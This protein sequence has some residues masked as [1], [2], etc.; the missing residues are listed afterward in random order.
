MAYKGATPN[1]PLTTYLV[2]HLLSREAETQY[3]AG[4]I[5]KEF[6]EPSIKALRKISERY[7]QHS[8]GT[9]L[10]HPV[11]T[12][13]EALAY[14]LYYLPVNFAKISRLLSY[15]SLPKNYS[16]LDY[17]SGPGTGALATL[18][19]TT[20]PS[21]IVCV[22]HSSQMRQ[23]ATRLVSP[24]K[25]SHPQLTTEYHSQLEEVPQA[26]NFN[27][28]IAANV[29][30]ELSVEEGNN[31][32]A[33]ILQRLSPKGYLLLIEPGQF[34]HTR[35]LM[36]IR[37]SVCGTHGDMTPIFPCC[38]KDVCPMIRTSETDWCH[39]TLQWDRPRL[40][41]QFDEA[42]E[43]NKHRLK[44]SAFIF[45]KEGD[46]PSGY[47]VIE[48]GRRDRKGIQATLCGKN[49]F[50]PVLLKPK[51]RSSENRALERSAVFD[52]LELSSPAKSN[53]PEDTQ[54]KYLD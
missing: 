41:Q 32:I 26:E 4:N 13:Q 8:V 20:K 9:P 11:N 2:K 17:G 52:R 12:E 15:C 7:T 23:I 34:A 39:G 31:I 45:Q 3:A 48:A 21:R 54:V 47:R 44:Y 37:D 40:I 6:L 1:D 18:F 28:I 25:L 51:T 24:Q 35:R 14:S 5:G 50:G 10:A 22:D 36:T 43:F 53:L 42:L 30:A 38:R 16:V 19:H 49:F 46:L 27:L 29:L 33:T